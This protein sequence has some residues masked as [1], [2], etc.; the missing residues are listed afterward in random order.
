M[1]ISIDLVAMDKIMYTIIS[2]GWDWNLIAVV[3]VEYM[4]S[5]YTEEPCSFPFPVGWWVNGTNYARC[6]IVVMLFMGLNKRPNFKIAVIDIVNGATSHNSLWTPC[7]RYTVCWRK[8]VPPKVTLLRQFNK[9]L[10]WHYFERK[11]VLHATYSFMYCSYVSLN[12]GTCSSFATTCRD[13]FSSA[14]VVLNG[15]QIDH[16]S[17]SW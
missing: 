7:V 11:H 5:G 10:V 8:I 4:S 1:G 15:F 14:R 17:K 13:I 2:F 9:H 16:S 12:S 3:S 6:H